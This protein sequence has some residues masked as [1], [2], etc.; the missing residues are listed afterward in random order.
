MFDTPFCETQIRTWS[1]IFRKKSE[2][3]FATQTKERQEMLMRLQYL[4]NEGLEDVMAILPRSVETPMIFG[5]NDI[6]YT[7][8]IVNEDDESAVRL[9][10]YEFSAPNFRGI[11]LANYCNEAIYL[12]RTP[13]YPFFEVHPELEL[14][15]DVV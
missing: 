5:H 10:D 1:E 6:R 13:E 3:H 15:E 2:Q 8:I 4:Y 9:V 12:Y 7:N 14:P 11:D